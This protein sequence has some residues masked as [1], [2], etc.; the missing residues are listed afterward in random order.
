MKL[1]FLILKIYLIFF[2]NMHDYTRLK[3]NRLNA[4]K[5]LDIF[6]EK[7]MHFY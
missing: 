5:T 2:L 7:K 6:Y 4:L 1:A 3:K